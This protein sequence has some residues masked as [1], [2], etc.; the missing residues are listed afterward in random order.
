MAAVG[1]YVFKKSIFGYLKEI[2]EE[3]KHELQL[4]DA[5]K[6]AIQNERVY[7]I[8]F[9]GLKFDIGDHAGYVKANIYAS[10]LDE[11][12]K[13]KVLEFIKKL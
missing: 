2:N 12:I 7:G 9:Y 6:M 11:Q 1:R 13:N 5:L 3:V 10:T 8:E 4:T